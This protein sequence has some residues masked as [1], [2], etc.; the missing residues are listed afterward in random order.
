MTSLSNKLAG[1]VLNTFSYGKHLDNMNGKIIVADEELG[2]RN[3]KHAG[4]CLCELWNHDPINGQSVIATYVEEYDYDVFSD[5]EEETWD[6]IDRHSQICKYFLDIHK[7]NN[8]N[9]CGPLNNGFLP[10]VI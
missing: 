2:C 9:C 10:P 8:R 3:F 5:T 1:I 4:E 7:C 6:W